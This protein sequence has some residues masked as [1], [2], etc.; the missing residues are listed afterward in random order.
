MSTIMTDL[1][2]IAARHRQLEAD[3]KNKTDALEVGSLHARR[4]KCVLMVTHPHTADHMSLA[5][6]K[7]EVIART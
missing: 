4:K 5:G 1:D 7:C 6:Q 2:Q 3:N